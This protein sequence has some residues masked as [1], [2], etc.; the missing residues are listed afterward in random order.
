MFSMLMFVSWFMGMSFMKNP[1]FMLIFE[2][3]G[4]IAFV[5]G[6]TGLISYFGEVTPHY[7]MDAVQGMQHN[8]Y[9]KVRKKSQ[10]H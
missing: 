10:K 1:W 8:I 4:Y 7:L 2:T 6:F 9:C 5:V 3:I